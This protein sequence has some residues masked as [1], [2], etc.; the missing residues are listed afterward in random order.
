MKINISKSS[1]AKIECG[2]Y[3]HSVSL[4]ILM[5]IA[6]GLNIDLDMLFKVDSREQQLIS[7][8]N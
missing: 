3:N 1:L 7:D 2:T 4:S 6:D 8:K 5:L